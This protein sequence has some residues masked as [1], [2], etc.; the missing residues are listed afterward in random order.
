[1]AWAA[2]LLRR[3]HLQAKTNWRRFVSRNYGVGRLRSLAIGPQN[4]L[5]AC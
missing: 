2:F 3:L 5:V 1:M 4:H